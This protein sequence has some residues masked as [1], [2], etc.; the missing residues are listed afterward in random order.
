MKQY[1]DG[2]LVTTQLA[3]TTT[4]SPL[5]VL[6]GMIALGRTNYPVI[7]PIRLFKTH[8]KVL[9]QEEVS[10]NFNKYQAQGLLN[11]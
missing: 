1:V 4:N 9:T 8:S 2:V 10:K 7:K 11:K 6:L 3:T 5:P